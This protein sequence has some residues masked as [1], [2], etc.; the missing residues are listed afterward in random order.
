MAECEQPMREALGAAPNSEVRT[1]E[2]FNRLMQ[3]AQTGRP[4]EYSTTETTLDPDVLD[5][6]AQRLT[7][8][9]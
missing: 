8:T 4:A 7:T 2:G 6:V 1:F 9:T 3:P 5:V